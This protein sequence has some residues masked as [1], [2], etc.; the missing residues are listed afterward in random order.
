MKRIPL[1]DL[2]SALNQFSGA[3]NS[4]RGFIKLTFQVS[5]NIFGRS[6]VNVLL[7]KFDLYQCDGMY[8]QLQRSQCKETVQG[9][10]E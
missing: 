4:V 9:V 5:W 8:E 3:N 7:V 6:S 10:A 2:S 1:L